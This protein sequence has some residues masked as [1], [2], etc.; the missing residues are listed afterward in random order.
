M[1]RDITGYIFVINWFPLNECIY[2]NFHCWMIFP[3]LLK[4]KCEKICLTSREIDVLAPHS[5]KKKYF[6]RL[7]LR[8]VS[9]FWTT[10]VH[11]GPKI[12]GRLISPKKSISQPEIPY[13]T[14]IIDYEFIITWCTIMSKMCWN[15]CPDLNF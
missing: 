9:L 14:R 15:V 1:L 12:R 8:A 11:K 3:S 13:L 5:T 4:R 7:P 2:W 10:T 6:F